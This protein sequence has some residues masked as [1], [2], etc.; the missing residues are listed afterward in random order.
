MIPVLR[1]LLS[2]TFP[3]HHPTLA[4]YFGGLKTSFSP[5]HFGWVFLVI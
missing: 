2:E 5:C 3:F 1:A 4:G